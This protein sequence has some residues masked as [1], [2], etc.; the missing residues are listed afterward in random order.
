MSADLHPLPR[1]PD[2]V[3]WPTDGWETAPP[4]GVD[5]DDLDAALGRILGPDQDPAVGHT[6]AVA[7]VQGGRIVAERYGERE[8][9]PL[10]ELAGVVP[11]PIGPDDLL[12]SWSMAKSVCHLLV[13][14]L[15]ERGLLRVTDP[16]PVPAWR[17]ADDPRS[18]ITWD[19]LLTMR[20]GLA[21]TEVY[22]G[23]GEDAVPDVVTMLYGDGA[24]DMAGFA[25]GFPLVHPPGSDDAYLYSSGTT[26]IVQGCL[27]R[28]AGVS[29]DEVTALLRATLL[30]PIG[31]GDV[32]LGF[33]GA[34]TWVAS[35][36]LDLVLR[37][38]LRLGLLVLRGGTWDGRAVVP[39]AWI[40]HGRTPRSV[41]D[42]DPMLV[43]GAH[44]W[45]RAGRDDGTFMAHGFE[46]QRL[47]MVPDRDLI[48]FRNGKTASEEIET[49][50]RLLYD[51]VDLFP[52][53]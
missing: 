46:G 44:W 39:A 17:S 2:G 3:A 10:A 26:N 48:V 52:R 32:R 31:A 14:V 43:H 11:G 37:D 27:Q 5:P 24:T 28:T 21:W 6:N 18:A 51:V 23:F 47:I 15:Q 8:T 30:D 29:G 4:S 35:S 7:V 33:D 40:D 41:R 34:G 25:A 20:P 13:G 22:E 38:W 19:D 16:A 1:Q 50:N 36:F 45:T 9:G 49:L 53:G 12:H 42:D